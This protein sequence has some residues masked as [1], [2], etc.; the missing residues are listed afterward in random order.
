LRQTGARDLQLLL[1]PSAP[2]TAT[3]QAR[4][5][6]LLAGFA[7]AQG[8]ADLRITTQS[9]DR[10]PLGRSGKLKRIVAAPEPPAAFR[11]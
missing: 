9:V 2:D 8:A 11:A 3:A 4:C 5:R 1:G 10:L 6:K 7:D